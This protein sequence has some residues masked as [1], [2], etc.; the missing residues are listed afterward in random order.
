[1]C[2]GGRVSLAAKRKR[3]PCALQCMRTSNN[4][5]SPELVRSA[6]TTFLVAP[7]SLLDVK[8]H[9]LYS[10]FST[11]CAILKAWYFRRTKTPRRLIFARAGHASLACFCSC[12]FF[13]WTDISSAFLN[14]RPCFSVTRTPRS[15]DFPLRLRDKRLWLCTMHR[16]SLHFRVARA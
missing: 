5:R 9:N 7:V 10:L 2:L 14:E 16:S 1:M 4:P 3:P 11:W 13:C 12:L 8:P 15:V 6:Y